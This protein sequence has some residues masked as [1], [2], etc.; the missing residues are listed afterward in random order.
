MRTILI[1]I[2]ATVTVVVLTLAGYGA[3]Y[4][5]GGIRILRAFQNGGR[6]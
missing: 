3:Y 4:V 5:T 6:R 1:S 2:G